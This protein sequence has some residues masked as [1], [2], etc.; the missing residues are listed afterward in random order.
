MYHVRSAFR[1]RVRLCVIM[2]VA[3]RMSMRVVVRASSEPSR[4]ERLEFLTGISSLV[5]P[6]CSFRIVELAHRRCVDV[7]VV[8]VAVAVVRRTPDHMEPLDSPSIQKPPLQKPA[9]RRFFLAWAQCWSYM[10][11]FRA[12]GPSWSNNSSLMQLSTFPRTL[13]CVSQS[14]HAWIF[15][16]KFCQGRR[17]ES[18]EIIYSSSERRRLAA[19]IQA[20]HE[21]E[22]YAVIN[23]H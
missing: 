14:R 23:S 20:I 2:A 16:S 18:D 10:D 21:M 11:A 17:R 4:R 1:V 3:F 22:N 12:N 7:F 19:H 8:V 5:G 6:T 9:S 13:R 15:C